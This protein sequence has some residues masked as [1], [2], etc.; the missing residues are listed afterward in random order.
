MVLN[1]D[2]FKF[3]KFIKIK[4]LLPFGENSKDKFI[5]FENYPRSY[6]GRDGNAGFPQ[7]GYSPESNQTTVRDIRLD[8]ENL[9]IPPWNK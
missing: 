6:R 4:Q 3:P 2:D 9:I 8:S 1:D 7:P 5:K